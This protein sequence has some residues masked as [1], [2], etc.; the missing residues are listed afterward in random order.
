MVIPDAERGLEG[1]GVSGGDGPPAHGVEE[2]VEPSRVVEVVGRRHREGFPGRGPRASGSTSQM[3]V[4]S[5]PSPS[6]ST[7]VELD[8]V[9]DLLGVAHDIAS[10]VPRRTSATTQ[11]RPR[12]L[13]N[14]FISGR[15]TTAWACTKVMASPRDGRIACTGQRRGRLSFCGSPVRSPVPGQLYA[16]IASQ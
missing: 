16:S 9:L 14:W 1:L 4:R 15:A 7:E 10:T 5:W 11:C 6:S 8:Q 12:T 2:G 3:T 13:T